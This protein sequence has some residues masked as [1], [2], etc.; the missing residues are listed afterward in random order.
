M[1]ERNG[2]DEAPRMAEQT[3]QPIDAQ[4]SR[5]APEPNLFVPR[6]LPIRTDPPFLSLPEQSTDLDRSERCASPVGGW[7][8]ET[9]KEELHYTAEPN[10]ALRERCIP[11]RGAVVAG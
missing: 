5:W 6:A 1:E 4:P 9:S 8:A 11:A 10:R 2:D 7:R 3:D